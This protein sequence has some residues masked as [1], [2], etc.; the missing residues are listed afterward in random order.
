MRIPQPDQSRVVLL[1]V[2]SY[3]HPGLP[4]VRAVG[5][6][7]E[8]LR[9]ALCDPQTGVFTLENC[10]SLIDPS[11]GYEIGPPLLRA[12][13]EAGDV[14]FVYYVGHGLVGPSG[15][16]YLATKQTDPDALSFS[17]LSYASIREALRDS[18]ARIRV[19][20]LDCCFSGRAIGQLADPGSVILGQ[21][22]VDGTYVLTATASNTPALA[23]DGAPHTAFTGTL[24]DILSGPARDSTGPLTLGEIYRQLRRIMVARG[25]PVPQQ[26]GTDTADLLVLSRAAFNS[27]HAAE[28]DPPGR[29]T[30][31]GTG[32][33]AGIPAFRQ[34]AR[35]PETFPRKQV[36]EPR[37]GRE[38]RVIGRSVQGASHV[39]RG[40]GNQDA[41]GWKP[42]GGAGLRVILSA[43]DGLG[44]AKNFRSSTGARFAIDISLDLASKLLEPA[45]VN[46]SFLKDRLQHDVPRQI[47]RHWRARVDADLSQSPIAETELAHLEELENRK[48]RELI[49]TNPHLAYGTGLVTVIAAESFMAFWQIGDGDALTEYATGEVGRPVPRDEPLMAGETVSLCSPDAWRMFRVAIFGTPAPVILVTT[50]GFSKEFQDDESFFKVSSDVREMILTDGMEAVNAR[51]DAWLREMTEQGGGDDV[52]LGIVSQPEESGPAGRKQ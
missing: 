29:P 31:S 44:G 5:R 33:P 2:G 50:G 38:W 30:A 45:Y 7:I 25:L 35:E 4:A 43:A 23:P 41:I 47:V 28:S 26:R 10:T 17:A 15:E 1:G 34:S 27:H 42:Q 13:R 18:P 49:E 16:L 22:A 36:T 19:V 6:N 20:V 24:L 14:L 40:I 51:L 21:L 12:A 52:T 32:A 37:A 3:M 48:S 11:S 8:D 39:R 9:T 46:L